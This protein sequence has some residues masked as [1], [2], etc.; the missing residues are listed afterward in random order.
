MGDYFKGFRVVGTN[1]AYFDRLT[2]GGGVALGMPRWLARLLGKPTAISPPRSFAFAAGRNFRD[3]EF[4][5]GV[6][7]SEVATKLGLKVGDPFSPTHGAD[8]G[9]VHDPFMVT[10]ILARTDTPVDRGVY[11]N[12]EGFYLQEGHAKPVEGV[13][14][15]PPE[16]PAGAGPAPLPREQR[17][18]TAV[19]V[20]TISQPGLPAEL[21]AM[22][23]R[24]RIN[25]GRDGQAA[26]PIREISVLLGLFVRPLELLLLLLTTL[27]VIVSAIGIL[28]S[29]VGSS[30]ERSRDVAVMRALGA[31]RSQVLATVL[32]EAV[33]LALGGG[34]VGWVL[35]HGIVAAIGPMIT[36]NAGVS[37]TFFSAAP[38]AELLLV[39][40]LIVLAI[41]AALL[42]ALAAYRTDV[43]KWLA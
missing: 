42:P 14:A 5:G 33:I 10:G 38:T 18:V 11:V 13:A 26:E 28:V 23:L 6:L 2:Y 15:R 35:G 40:F 4:F 16:T 37:A 39:P 7:G 41:L 27:V 36:T 43:A 32:I 8:D 3:D 21:A 24:T 9:L 30:L 31:R 17:E 12:M 22:A 34:L 1:A 19:L 20:E 25:E 29:M